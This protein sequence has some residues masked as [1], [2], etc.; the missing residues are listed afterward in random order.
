MARNFMSVAERFGKSSNFADL[1]I[2]PSA[3]YQLA[4]PSVPDEARQA[5]AERAEAGEQMT[6]KVVKEIVARARKKGR[7]R[8][9]P[10]PAEKLGLGLVKVLERYR[11][12]WNP[13]ELA[14]LARRLRE[15]ADDLDSP[16]G[17]RRT[18]E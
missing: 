12:R 10:L 3:A 1:P 15:F 18:K 8:G 9:K 16:R 2:Q 6:M 11:E 5:A 17:S 4:A 7:R 14:E 13:R